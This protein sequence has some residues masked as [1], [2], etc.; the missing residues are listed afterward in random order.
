[1]KHDYRTCIER[2]FFNSNELTKILLSRLSSLKRGADFRRFRR[3]FCLR[4]YDFVVSEGTIIL[5]REKERESE[6]SRSCL[7]TVYKKHRSARSETA[8]ICTWHSKIQQQTA[9]FERLILVSNILQHQIDFRLHHCKCGRVQVMSW[10]WQKRSPKNQ[11]SRCSLLDATRNKPET[12]QVVQNLQGARTWGPETVSEGIISKPIRSLELTW[13]RCF[14][15][16]GVFS[17]RLFP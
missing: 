12:A 13:R 16:S 1:M 8:R 17:Q 10:R 5:R 11:P 9:N 15:Q 4:L 6:L 14:D 7:V 2:F 3:V